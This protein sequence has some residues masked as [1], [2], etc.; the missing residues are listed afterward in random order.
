MEQRNHT[1]SNMPRGDDAH[2]PRSWERMRPHI[3]QEPISE[4]ETTYT[5]IN[6]YT[7]LEQQKRRRRHMGTASSDPDYLPSVNTDSTQSQEQRFDTHSARRPLTTKKSPAQ[8]RTLHFDRYLETPKPGKSIFTAR[9]HR[10]DTLT[11]GILALLIC[12]STIL[13]TLWFFFLR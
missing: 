13:F 3:S 5:T 4:D 9:Q 8:R 6:R 11:K 12:V 2:T 1:T 10:Y 7:T